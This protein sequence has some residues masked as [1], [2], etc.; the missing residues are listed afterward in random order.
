MFW[1][2]PRPA[3]SATSPSQT[4]P[5]PSFRQPVR[6]A[7]SACLVGKFQTRFVIN[8]KRVPGLTFFV[9]WVSDIFITTAGPNDVLDQWR[10]PANEPLNTINMLFP[11]STLLQC[12]DSGISAAGSYCPR[13]THRG[14]SETTRPVL[15]A[16]CHLL[17]SVSCSLLVRIN[18]SSCLAR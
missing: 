5:R 7:A 3:P 16:T 4:Q 17:L 11:G 13:N 15:P 8:T 14:R 6:S 9:V 10:T 2:Q 18:F 1:R 12:C